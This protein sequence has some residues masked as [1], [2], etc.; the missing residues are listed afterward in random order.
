VTPDVAVPADQ[1]LLTAQLMAMKPL[2]EAVKEPRM[3][4]GAAWKMGEVQA[5]LDK[6]KAKPAL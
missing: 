1:A 4:E 3:R 6:L 5:E 2:V